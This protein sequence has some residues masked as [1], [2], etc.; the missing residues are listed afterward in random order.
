MRVAGTVFYVAG[1]AAHAQTAQIRTG[2]AAFNDYSQQAPGVMRKITV[3]DLPKPYATESVDSGSPHIPRPADAWPKTLPGFKVDLY[4]TGLDNPRLIRTAPNGDLF[5]A[6]SQSNK[7]KIFRSVT[8]Q[9]KVREVHVYATGL[10]QPFGIAFYPLGANPKWVYIANTDSVVRYPNQNG[11][12]R[13]APTR[14]LSFQL[15]PAV[16]GSAAAVTGR[17]TLRF[18]KT[19]SAC[20]FLSAHSRT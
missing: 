2:A 11:E 7:I 1:V 14:K 17:A 8:P 16:A 18:Q 13:R 20:G 5:L 15:C 4:S 6:E 12:Q 10:K 19:A 3:A 9:G